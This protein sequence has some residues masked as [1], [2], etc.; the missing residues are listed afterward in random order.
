VAYFNFNKITPPA[1]NDPLVDEATQLNANWDHLDLKLQPYM[2][3]GSMTGLETGQEY[4]SGGA[5]NFTVW[6]GAAGVVPD[7]IAEGWTAWANIPMLAPRAIRSGFQP[8]WRSNPLIRMVE[9][10][11]GI[12]FDGAAGAWTMGSSFQFNQLA[13]GSPA[14]SFGPIGGKHIAQCAAALTGG[15][16]VAASGYITID[17]SGSFVRMA[18]QYLGGGGGGNFIM[19]DQVWW[20]Y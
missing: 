2:L 15:T 5:F 13:S 16:S 7:D 20:W 11:G 19:L 10:T 8:K 3:G 9:L 4:F 14:L 6:D 18:A 1:P 12:Q 17:T